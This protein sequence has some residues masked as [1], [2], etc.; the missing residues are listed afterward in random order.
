MKYQRFG[1]AQVRH[2][3]S[4]LGRVYK[5]ERRLSAIQAESKQPTSET[6]K[7]VF[8]SLMEPTGL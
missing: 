8:H 6:F 3:L 1:I 7:E 4:K 2:I 5:L